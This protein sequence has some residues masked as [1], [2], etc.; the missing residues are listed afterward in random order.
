MR[1][2]LVLV[3]LALSL[4]VNAWLALRPEKRVV[5]AP[6]ANSRPTYFT[7]HRIGEA[8]RV[9][10]GRGVRIGIIDNNFGLDAHRALYAGA[11]DFLDD[12]KSLH[13]YADHGLWLATTTREVAPGAE[14]WALNATA[15]DESRRVAGV[16]KAL[17]WAAAN[18]LDVVTYSNRPFSPEFRPRVDAAAE[19]AIAAGV[20]V[21][22]T[23]Y[24]H[25]KNLLPF[26]M[27][28]ADAEPGYDRPGDVN[29][30]HYDYN[31][32]DVA[33]WEKRSRGKRAVPPHLSI[34]STSVVLAGAVAMLREL[35]R[36]LSPAEC[37]EILV[38]TSRPYVEAPR[39]GP[40]VI[41][42]CPRVLDA[43]AAVE[44]VRAR[45]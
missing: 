35:D 42:S 7:M 12:P 40:E 11:E 43:M 5:T 13:E 8:Q 31:V 39:S 1:K 4:G 44:R 36:T 22:F 45:G 10:T 32:L 3:P 9:A 34:S 18:K 33:A 30:L 19:K 14:I 28:P 37:K 20:V 24:T 2:R 25:P 23:H 6:N 27:L 16:V 29:V 38:A 41:R 26:P 17:D 15:G 21:V